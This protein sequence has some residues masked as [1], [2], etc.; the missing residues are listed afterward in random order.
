MHGQFPLDLGNPKDLF[1][2]SAVSLDLSNPK[3]S[4]YVV[5]SI[6]GIDR[7]GLYAS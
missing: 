1:Y 4:F 7:S 6:S 5:C 2:A 3:D